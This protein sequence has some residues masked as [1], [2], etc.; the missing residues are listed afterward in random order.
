MRELL[1]ANHAHHTP[2]Y[3]WFHNTLPHLKR[4]PHRL[5]GKVGRGG[6]WKRRL[7]ATLLGTSISL[8]PFW[9][10]F[11]KTFNYYEF[12]FSSKLYG[13]PTLGG[14]GETR[15]FDKVGYWAGFWDNYLPVKHPH[16]KPPPSSSEHRNFFSPTPPCFTLG[17]ALNSSPPTIP[18]FPTIMPANKRATP[19]H[20]M[21]PA[22]GS[23]G[24]LCLQWGIFYTN[25]GLLSS[26]R[27]LFYTNFLVQVACGVKM[28][29][30][31]ID[32]N[33]VTEMFTKCMHLCLK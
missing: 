8:R 28:V 23:A 7:T 12:Y 18:A 4:F 3:T 9:I 30:P 1:Q 31:I 22:A 29:T 13:L 32:R 16:P 6:R 20:R 10:L 27:D 15:W 17:S 26:Q 5:Q 25:F 24:L 33:Y 2:L 21:K 19:H 11:L 14:G